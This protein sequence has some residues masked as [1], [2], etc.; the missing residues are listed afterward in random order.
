MTGPAPNVA[1]GARPRRPRCSRSPSPLSP[2]PPS[3]LSQPPAERPVMM[4]PSS[5]TPR[6]RWLTRIATAAHP[7]HGGGSPGS[8]QGLARIMAGTLTRITAAAAH[9][10]HGGGGS[11]GSRRR[12][13]TRIT[14]AAAH[15]DHGGGSP[16][17]RR[18]WFTRITAAAVQPDHGGGSPGSRRRRLVRINSPARPRPAGR[19]ADGGRRTGNASRAAADAA[20]APGTPLA[21]TSHDTELGLQ[22]FPPPLESIGSAAGAPGTPPTAMWPS[23]ATRPGRLTAGN[24]T[25]ESL[26][27]EPSITGNE[28][29]DAMA[30]FICTGG[31]GGVGHHA[32]GARGAALP[33]RAAMSGAATTDA[34]TPCDERG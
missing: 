15:P 26:G 8:L 4:L 21:S 19:W 6:Q 27:M 32:R 30:V 24:E 9:P 34:W 14:A 2:L 17:S 33:G 10:D 13:L 12:R 20:G 22:A 31:A 25:R 11:P 7:D 29:S 16:E 1:K 18:R 23:A 5:R 3:L 28:T